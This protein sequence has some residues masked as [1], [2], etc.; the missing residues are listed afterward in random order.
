MVNMCCNVSNMVARLDNDFIV[1]IV[2]MLVLRASNEGEGLRPTVA[3]LLEMA[4]LLRQ[5]V[6]SNQSNIKSD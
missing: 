3:S 6:M 5:H 2:N 1:G 4:V